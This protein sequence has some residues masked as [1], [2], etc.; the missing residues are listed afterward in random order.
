MVQCNQTA[1]IF[2]SN[3]ITK[4]ERRKT[5]GEIK[6]V[7]AC[8]HDIST[9]RMIQFKW[10]KELSSGKTSK[11]CQYLKAIPLPQKCGLLIVGWREEKF[12]KQWNVGCSQ[13][14][15]VLKSQ[16]QFVFIIC[17]YVIVVCSWK[18]AFCQIHVARGGATHM[19]VGVPQN[20]KN[21]SC[22]CV[23]I[24]IYIYIYI[25]MIILTF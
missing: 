23:Y 20:L 5:L 9:L 16:V 8:I 7:N 19:R 11:C 25:Y 4:Y 21:N 13:C 14:S 18:E 15:N 1:F 24:F 17:L 2:Q 3:K 22:V 10:I 12:E 6:E